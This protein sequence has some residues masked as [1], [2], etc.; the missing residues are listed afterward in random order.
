MWYHTGM[1]KSRSHG[2]KRVPLVS[3]TLRVPADVHAHLER[4]SIARTWSIQKT[5]N[6]LIK[7]ATPLD[8]AN[9]IHRRWMEA[10]IRDW[11]LALEMAK[12]EDAASRL[13]KAA[14]QALIEKFPPTQQ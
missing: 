3:L 11:Q 14:R 6:R 5:L 8:P 12:A 1:K 13:L 4:E 7:H 2:K 10:E 9:P